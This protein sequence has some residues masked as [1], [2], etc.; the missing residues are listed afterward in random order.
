MHRHAVHGQ[1]T[2]IYIF[3]FCLWKKKKK[4]GGGYGVFWRRGGV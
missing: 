3:I 4:G 1:V 2:K